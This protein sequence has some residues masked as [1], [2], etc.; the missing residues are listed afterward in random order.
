MSFIIANIIL[1]LLTGT[2]VVYA[3]AGTVPTASTVADVVEE[4]GVSSLCLTPL[5]LL[6]ISQDAE[7]QTRIAAHVKRIVYA[8]GDLPLSIGNVLADTFQLT[9]VMA[10]TEYGIFHG[11]TPISLPQG[12]KNEHWHALGFHPASN[13]HFV[14]READADIYEAVVRRKDT[15]HTQTVFRLFPSSQ[16]VATGDLYRKHASV[17]GLWDYAGR[18]DDMIIFASGEKFWPLDVERRISQHADVHEALIIGTGRERVVLLLD[19]PAAKELGRQEAID[20][21]WP[22]IEATH[23][24]CSPAAQILREFI[25]V[26]DP[27]RPFVRTPKGSVQ[28]GDTARLYAEDIAKLDGEAAERNIAAPPSAVEILT[29]GV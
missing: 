6:Q 7:L 12:K 16:E 20:R 19:I 9:N 1:P 28:R 5:T 29:K 2:T 22:V 15:G 24:A 3:P 17:D 4:T 14:Q 25:L 8:G 21:I 26:A 27:E 11:I 23:D 13:V 10:S 18:S